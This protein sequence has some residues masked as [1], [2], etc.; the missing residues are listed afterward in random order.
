MY[1]MDHFSGSSSYK[2]WSACIYCFVLQ[3]YNV[4]ILT[5]KGAAPN[6]MRFLICAAFI[7]IGSVKTLF[8]KYKIKHYVADSVSDPSWIRV[9]RIRIQNTGCGSISEF[10]FWIR[11]LENIF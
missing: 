6:I 2:Y 5:M 3:T 7:Y 8:D 11:P 1:Q 4:L 9:K 10:F